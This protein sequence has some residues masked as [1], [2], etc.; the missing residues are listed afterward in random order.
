M[1]AYKGIHSDADDGKKY[2]VNEVKEFL[3]SVKLHTNQGTIALYTGRQAK[4]PANPMFNY[5]SYAWVD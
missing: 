5:Q 4:D 3:K 1:W 2:I